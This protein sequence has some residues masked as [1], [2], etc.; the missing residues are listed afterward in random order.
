MRV[1]QPPGPLAGRIDFYFLP[2]AAAASALGNKSLAVLAVSSPKR[3][4][5]L[6]DVPSTAEAGYPDAEFRFWTGLSAPVKTPRAVVDKLHDVAEQAL[7]VPALQEKL[8][9]LGVNPEHMSVDEFGRFFRD[10]LAAT[11]KLAN[12]AHIEPID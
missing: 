12:D 4:P 5:L 11:V 6:P 2:L 1:G 8:A 9:K 3:I 7:G 10:D